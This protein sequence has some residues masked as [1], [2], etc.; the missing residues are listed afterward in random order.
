MFGSGFLSVLNPV[1]A[2]II[3]IIPSF[4]DNA[5]NTSSL[6]GTGRCLSYGGR[7][8][9]TI[10]YWLVACFNGVERGSAVGMCNIDKHT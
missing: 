3:P 8:A 4:S 7:P 10:V 5:C 6:W 9:M 1:P 2:A